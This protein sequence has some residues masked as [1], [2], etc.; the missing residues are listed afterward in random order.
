MIGNIEP[1]IPTVS[2]LDHVGLL[3]SMEPCAEA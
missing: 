2:R 1:V 3:I